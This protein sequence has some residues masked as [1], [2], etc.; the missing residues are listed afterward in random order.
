VR[1]DL[2]PETLDDLVPVQRTARLACPT[3]SKSTLLHQLP[4]RENNNY[5]SSIR[6]NAPAR[7]PLLKKYYCADRR[8]AI[9][10]IAGRRV[11]PQSPSSLL[12][13]D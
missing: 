3:R 2:R 1:I 7:K 9:T 11:P 5:K 12:R 10:I 6:P 13:Y 4:R 8:A